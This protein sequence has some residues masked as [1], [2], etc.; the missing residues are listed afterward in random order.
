MSTPRRRAARSGNRRREYGVDPHDSP[1]A[2]VCDE[3]GASFP[4]E[5]EMSVSD[6]DEEVEIL[7]PSCRMARHSDARHPHAH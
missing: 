2:A 7:C 5:R 4:Y 1:G 3:C 6:E